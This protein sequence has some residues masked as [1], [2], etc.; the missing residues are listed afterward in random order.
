MMTHTELRVFVIAVTGLI[1]VY[2]LSIRDIIAPWIANFLNL[3]A[4]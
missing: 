3:S 4:F 1:T 2:L